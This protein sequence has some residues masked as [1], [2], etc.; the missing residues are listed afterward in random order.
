MRCQQAEYG[1][2]RS[3]MQAFTAA[4][5]VARKIKDTGRLVHVRVMRDGKPNEDCLSLL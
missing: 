2:F 3:Q 4:V 5:T 1:R